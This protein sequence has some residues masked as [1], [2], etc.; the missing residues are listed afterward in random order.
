MS[1]EES[2]IALANTKE[3]WRPYYFEAVRNGIIV[4]GC[5]TTTF[6]SGP[7]KGKIKYLTNENAMTVLIVNSEAVR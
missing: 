4:K 3:G 7:R 6:K 1:L 5:Q 2:A